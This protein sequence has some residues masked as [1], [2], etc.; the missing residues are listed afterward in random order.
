MTEQEQP[1]KLWHGVLQGGRY[2][3]HVWAY[4]AVEA[5]STARKKYDEAH[6]DQEDFQE[7][8]SCSH[9]DFR[10]ISPSQGGG[11]FHFTRR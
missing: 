2:V 6:E 8:Y 3:C 1:L 4:T 10:E 7:L 5:A 9:K 11:T